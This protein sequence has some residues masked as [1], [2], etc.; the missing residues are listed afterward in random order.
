[1]YCIGIGKYTSPL[2]I[3]K[4][5]KGNSQSSNASVFRYD[6]FVSGFRYIVPKPEFP[7]KKNGKR[8]PFGCVAFCCHSIFGRCW[9]TRLHHPRSVWP[10]HVEAARLQLTNGDRKETPR[11]ETPR[12]ALI[13]GME[14]QLV[15]TSL[16]FVGSVSGAFR[17]VCIY[18]VYQHCT[19]THTHFNYC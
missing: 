9:V 10:I 5:P 17:N 11:P 15:G 2:K 14:K 1:M 18:A 3:R 7:S 16:G 12:F 13:S 8:T 6:L 19:H 4:S